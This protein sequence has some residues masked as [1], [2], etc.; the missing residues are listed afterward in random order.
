MRQLCLDARVF[1]DKIGNCSGGRVGQTSGL[2]VSRASG[3]VF[4]LHQVHG[5]GGSVMA[6]RRSAPHLNSYFFRN[7]LGGWFLVGRTATVTFCQESGTSLGFHPGAF[8]RRWDLAVKHDPPS[9]PRSAGLAGPVRFGDGF[10]H[11]LAG[12]CGHGHGQIDG[13]VPEW[14]KPSGFGLPFYS[15]LAFYCSLKHSI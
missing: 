8:G 7:C 6:D 3:P 5:A 11:A 1:Q 10:E 15:R 13:G 14:P 2:P 9:A 12:A 4:R